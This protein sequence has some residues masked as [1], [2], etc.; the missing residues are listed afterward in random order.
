MTI[1]ILLILICKNTI[2]AQ[3]DFLP[4]IQRVIIKE[5]QATIIREAELSLKKD[6]LSIII[7][8]LPGK[9]NTNSIS[10]KIY[11]N[12]EKCTYKIIPSID[13]NLIK[14]KITQIN[15]SINYFY[16]T[17]NILNFKEKILKESTSINISQIME[18]EDISDILDALTKNYISISSQK[19]EIENKIHNLLYQKDSLQKLI[20]KI[21][22]DTLPSLLLNLYN[23]KPNKYTLRISYTVLN[24]GWNVEYHLNLT[25]YP[26][27]L[28]ST[29]HF[30]IWQKT[31]EKWNKIKTSL[32]S[33]QFNYISTPNSPYKYEKLSS[34]QI[35]YELNKEI[36]INSDDTFLLSY[37]E[38]PIPFQLK[39]IAYPDTSTNVHLYLIISQPYAYFKNN[40]IIKVFLDGISQTNSIFIS[41][42]SN[43][44]VEIYLGIDPDVY[45][46]KKEIPEVRKI[47]NKK[48]YIYFEVLEEL[49]CINNHNFPVKVEIH[50]ASPSDSEKDS[51]ITIA[52]KLEFNRFKGK[53]NVV[54]VKEIP[55][56]S[57]IKYNIL[58][59]GFKSITSQ[60]K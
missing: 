54:W 27:Q 22:D 38:K 53:K 33:S 23:V 19:K 3:I 40:S 11:P 37:Q 59:K 2:N 50:I 48:K 21:K 17:V 47:L 16:Y 14:S 10:L 1:I 31:G 34:S 44:Q 8:P 46:I 35:F 15:D 20:A 45:F 4:P 28:T 26:P 51:E 12:I 42:S 24:A 56:K 30:L 7:G 43:N 9:V 60:K 57:E 39:R 25:N 52:E 18:Y 29:T 13:T 32:I 58:K 41:D 49:T 6:T 5:S 55:Q 36:S